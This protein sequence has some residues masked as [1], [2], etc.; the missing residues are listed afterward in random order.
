MFTKFY[1]IEFKYK[2][3]GDWYEGS[4]NLSKGLLATWDE[5]IAGLEKKGEM[6]EGTCNITKTVRL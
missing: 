5:V 1:Y 4:A 2:K 3:N 6:E